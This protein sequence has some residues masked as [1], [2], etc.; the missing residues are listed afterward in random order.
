LVGF[1]VPSGLVPRQSTT[2]AAPSASTVALIA[3]FV[4]TVALIAAAFNALAALTIALLG[5]VF[6]E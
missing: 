5:V 4:L 6:R 2:F 3:A 1:A